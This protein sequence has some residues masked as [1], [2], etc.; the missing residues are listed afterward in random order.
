MKTTIKLHFPNAGGKLEHTQLLTLLVGLHSSD[1]FGKQVSSR[2]P[3]VTVPR[4]RPPAEL[5]RRGTQPSTLSG[6]RKGVG[7]EGQSGGRVSHPDV[8]QQQNGGP[9]V[10]RRQGGE[11]MS[12]AE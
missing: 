3:A 11:P 1:A 8:L 10:Q 7:C 12:P 2:G 9:N 6:V 5:H 4:T